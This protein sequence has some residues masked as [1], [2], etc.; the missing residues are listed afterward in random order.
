MLTLLLDCDVLVNFGEMD[1]MYNESCGDGDCWTVGNVQ[2]NLIVQDVTVVDWWGEKKRLM[3]EKVKV[4]RYVF[5]DLC[6]YWMMIGVY[7]LIYYCDIININLSMYIYAPSLPRP[8]KRQVI[9]I[10]SGC[11]SEV[12]DFVDLAG[13][14]MC[15]SVDMLSDSVVRWFGVFWWLF[16]HADVKEQGAVTRKIR[17]I[18]MWLCWFLTLLFWRDR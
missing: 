1:D 8:L 15:V 3:S 13:R 12:E 5:C 18:S 10:Q 17:W 9:K 14:I 16:W 4:R 11:G 6:L 7:G 2:S